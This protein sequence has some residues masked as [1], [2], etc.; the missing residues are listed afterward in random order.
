MSFQD[1]N[2]RISLNKKLN[3]VFWTRTKRRIHKTD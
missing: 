2:T 3:L 1:A